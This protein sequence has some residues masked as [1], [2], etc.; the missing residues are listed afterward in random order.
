MRAAE[1]KTQ[2]RWSPRRESLRAWCANTTSAFRE[3]AGSRL[4]AHPKPSKNASKC[5]RWFCA[6]ALYRG[7][8][9]L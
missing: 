5:W 4:K 9:S 2:L 6:P 1:W 7:A 8:A 3:T